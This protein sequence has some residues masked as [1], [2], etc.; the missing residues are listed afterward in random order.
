MHVQV[1]ASTCVQQAPQNNGRAGSTAARQTGQGQLRD[2]QTSSILLAF[3]KSPQPG[4]TA[5]L[6]TSTTA[7][8]SVSKQ[9]VRSVAHSMQPHCTPCLPASDSYCHTNKC[10][11]KV[12]FVTVP[13]EPHL[14]NDWCHQSVVHTKSDLG[15]GAREESDPAL[16]IL[17][18]LTP[19]QW[20]A[21]SRT[22]SGRTA[23]A[24]T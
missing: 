11:P 17:H 15:K 16:I 5:A 6:P 13:S 18:L 7:T 20:T 9:K 19:V 22:G 1:P 10:A 8:L 12:L 21:T 2:Q 23:G 4:Q 14:P 3:A 24:E